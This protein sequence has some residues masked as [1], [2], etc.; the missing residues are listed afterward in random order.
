[1]QVFSTVE[2]THSCYNVRQFRL[3]QSIDIIH[4][5]VFGRLS[6][7]ALLENRSGHFFLS[8]SHSHVSSELLSDPKVAC[9][10]VPT[11]LLVHE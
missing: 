5:S 1:M 11:P 9:V 7:A 3:A 10:D 2:D 6:L 8:K 4:N